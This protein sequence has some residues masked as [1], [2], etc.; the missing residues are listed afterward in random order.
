[1]YYVVLLLAS[2]TVQCTTHIER[3]HYL[4]LFALKIE[5]KKNAHRKEKSVWHESEQF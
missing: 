1:M 5:M 4:K 3:K 2:V